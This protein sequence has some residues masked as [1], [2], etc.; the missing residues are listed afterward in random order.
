MEGHLG[1]FVC[2]RC[3]TARILCLL[4]RFE[5]DSC[6]NSM[7]PNIYWTFL[8]FG[9]IRQVGAHDDF[10]RGPCSTGSLVASSMHYANTMVSPWHLKHPHRSHALDLTSHIKYFLRPPH[11]SLAQKPA[12]SPLISSKRLVSSVSSLSVNFMAVMFSTWAP[13]SLPNPAL[14]RT[15]LWTLFTCMVA[16]KLASHWSLPIF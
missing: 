11:S 16:S 5:V 15:L 7:I 3:I 1:S 14:S 6:V 8:V 4:L 13:S 12:I 2:D 9:V 10:E